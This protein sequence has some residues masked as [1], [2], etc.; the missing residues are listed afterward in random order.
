MRKVVGGWKRSSPEQLVGIPKFVA[1]PK[2][3]ELAAANTGS[4]YVIP[5]SVPI[6][7]QGSLDS[8]VANATCG[9]F[10]ILANVANS[11]DLT[12]LSRLF[13]Y[14]NARVYIQQTNQDAGCYIHD[15]LNS[16]S[17]LGICQETLWPYI[18]SEV[19]VQPPI[20]AYQ[21][22]NA[23]T[24][25]GFSQIIETGTALG[26]MIVLALQA[27][28]PVVFGTLVSSAFAE[29]SGNGIGI[30]WD[31]PNES[32]IDGGHAMVICGYQI[33]ADGTRNFLIR[34]SW[35]ATWA[36]NG[37]TWFTEAYIEWSNTSDI[38]IATLMPNLLA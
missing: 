20:T 6:F 13:L 24:I 7:D 38:F 1:S 34:N 31:I 12:V 14:W 28:H 22:A 15:A 26:D 21:Q 36:N 10:E 33:N 4:S 30:V 9:A 27:N 8:C 5:N 35:G 19:L 25:T 23:N 29:Y 2:V 37:T 3:L 17:L 18:E 32:D 11:N 16:L